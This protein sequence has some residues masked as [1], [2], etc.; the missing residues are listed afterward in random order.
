M[1][2]CFKVELQPLLTL[3]CNRFY[4]FNKLNDDKSIF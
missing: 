4:K 1:V 3:L 2:V